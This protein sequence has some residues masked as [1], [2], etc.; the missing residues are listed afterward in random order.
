MV[1]KMWKSVFCVGMACLML[2]ATAFAFEQSVDASPG[3]EETI[4]IDLF[5]IG[6]EEPRRD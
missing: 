1:R 4:E 2:V 3:C 6:E 5:I